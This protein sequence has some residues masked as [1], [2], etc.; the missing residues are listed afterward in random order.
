MGEA[1]VA[2]TARDGDQW[3]LSLTDA[4]ARTGR[5]FIVFDGDLVLK[6]ADGLVVDALERKGNL[7]MFP[8]N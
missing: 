7:W 2:G 8:C 5:L 4:G 3:V 1:E 6:H